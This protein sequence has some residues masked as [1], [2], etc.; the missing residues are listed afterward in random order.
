MKTN[1]DL[2]AHSA[3]GLGA[4]VAHAVV[5][6]AIPA[7]APTRS[8]SQRGNQRNVTLGKATGRRALL[9]NGVT[10]YNVTLGSVTHYMRAAMVL[11]MML[12][13]TA[14][15]WADGDVVEVSQASDFGANNSGEIWL[16]SKTYKLTSDIVL[17]DAYLHSSNTATIDLNGYGIRFNVYGT[18]QVVNVEG[19]LTIIDSNPSR[20]NYITLDEN[21]RGTS[22]STS[23]T[24]S[25]TCIKV[26]GGYITGGRNS[27]V[28][29]SGT[30]T[31][32]GGTIC[33]NISANSGGGVY[34]DA[35]GVFTMN[36]GT[37]ANNTCNGNDGVGGVYVKGAFIM[38]S[39]TVENNASVSSTYQNVR[40]TGGN[41]YLHGGCSAP[42]NSS[43]PDARIG[44]VSVGESDYGTITAS[45]ADNDKVTI[46]D[47]TYFKV[48][49]TVTLSAAPKMNYRLSTVS[50][51][52][53]GDSSSSVEVSGTGNTRTFT[54]PE[55]DVDVSAEY[56]HYV[57]E[58]SDGHDLN[59]AFLNGGDYILKNDIP[60]EKTSLELYQKINLD[61]NG[62]LIWPED[63][64]A[65]SVIEIYTGGD[66][67]L[68]DSSEGKEGKIHCYHIRRGVYIEGGKLTLEGGTITEGVANGKTEPIGK[69]GGGVCI[70]SGSFTMNGGKITGCNSQSR[71]EDGGGGG[72]YVYNGRFTMN[73]GEISNNS[74]ERGGGVFVR[75]IIFLYG[76]T[77]TS[78]KI[79]I[80]G[81]GGGVYY[82]YN[83]SSIFGVKGSPVVTGNLKEGTAD[84][85][86][87]AKATTGTHAYLTISGAL[88]ESAALWLANGSDY[89]CIAKRLDTSDTLTQREAAAFRSSDGTKVG[90]KISSSQ[91]KLGTPKTA[92][93][94]FSPAGGIFNTAQS[95]TISSTTDGATIYYTTDGTDPSSTNGTVYTAAIPVST[96]TTI[97]AIAIK[98]GLLNSEIATATYTI[99]N[100]TEA[101]V[102]IS[103][104]GVSNGAKTVTYGTSPFTLT[105]SADPAG[106]NGAWT[107]ASSDEQVATVDNTGKVTVKAASDEPVMITASYTSDASFGSAAISLTVNKATPTYTVPT[108]LTAT[109]GQILADVTLPD[110]WAWDDDSQLVGAVGTNSFSATFTPDD[111]DNYNNVTTNVS[112]TVAFDA[113]HFA[114]NGDGSYTIKTATGWGV[115]CDLLAA[116]G[117][118]TYFS[119]KTVKLSTDIGTADEPITRMAGSSQHDFTGTFDGQGHTLTV[120][121]NTSEKYAAPFRNVESGCVI[122]NLHVAGTITTSAM[123]AAGI[124]GNQFGS[125]TIRNCRVSVTISSSVGGDG[126]HGGF[127]GIKGNSNAAQLTIDGCV[128]DGKIVSTGDDATTQ[129]GGFVGWRKDKGSLTITNSLYAP[130]ADD[131]AVTDGAT[132][133]RNWSMPADA[134]CYYTATLGSAQGKQPHSV[135]AGAN[136]TIEPIALTGD[137]TAYDVSGIKAYSGGGIHYGDNLYYGSG[138]AVSLTLADDAADAPTG[139]ASQDG[140]TVSAGTLSGS[141][142]TMPDKDVVVTVRWAPDPEHFAKSADGSEYTIKTATGWNVFCD[143]LQDLNTYNRFS[144]KKVTLYGDIPTADEK[145]AGTS[146]VTRMAGTSQHDFCGTFDGQG[147]TLTVNLSSTY[148]QDYTAPFSYVTNAKANPGDTSDSPAA[149]RNLKVTGT[150]ESSHKFASGLVGGCWG[151]VD[152]ENS[153]VSTV[154][155][156]HVD[157]DG[158]HGG[159]VGRQGNGTLTIRGCVFDGQL[160]GSD[161]HSCAGFVGYNNGSTLNISNS[162]FAPASVTVDDDNCATFARHGENN[163]TNID[164]CYYT[165]TLGTE[166]GEEGILLFDS[167]VTATANEGVI[168]RCATKQYDVKLQGRTLYK[169]GK[170]NTLCLPFDVE[171]GDTE[172]GLT[173]SGTPLAGAEARP[174]SAAS[175]TGTTLTLTFGNPVST[176]VAGTPYIIK[177]GNTEGTEPT[178]ATEHIVNPV[179]S[180]VTISSTTAGSYDTQSAS[181]AVTTDA[182]VRFIGTYDQKTIDTEDKS[183]LFLGAGNTLYYPDGTGSGVTIGACRAYFKI[184]DGEALARQLTAFNI[185]FGEETGIGHTEITEITERAGAWYTLDGVRL[186]G[187]PT[188]RS[189]EGRLLPTGRKKG[190]YIHN[191]RKVVVP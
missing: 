74:A 148:G 16:E 5:A 127:V 146:A 111:T 182:R 157:G 135:T 119:G 79:P 179:F 32:N 9:G 167:G 100:K 27:G 105:A 95:V 161:T 138:D 65:E 22:V 20:I 172:D 58:I 155:D 121:Y 48:G 153:L 183:I 170:W 137:E 80:N 152:I 33:G 26:Y 84:D 140:Y 186:D 187:K 166:Q 10:Y 106:T 145:A 132:F 169:D 21:G 103:G 149:I 12:L 136:V 30:L 42:S 97:K 181:P 29:V 101:T 180:G 4:V 96:T 44:I 47:D 165:Q 17:N 81:E 77:I 55:Y 134:N 57:I 90:K 99:V 56:E 191:G 28:Y 117:G 107:W 85:I 158:T 92:Q 98:E 178:E 59:S 15:A 63:N 24:E 70:Y 128:F 93:P 141:T 112:V 154:I 31:M 120:D 110:N 82:S 86:Y 51:T 25:N 188:K 104:E 68:T 14:T 189:A 78:N 159:I 108:G 94:T 143:A 177:W 72:V 67:T 60:L 76:G 151:V 83:K 139:Y 164:N 54:M 133:A 142:L 61:L 13:T 184:G 18:N 147:H 73:G 89:D 123:N 2:S 7:D 102:S 46:G 173:F 185:D 37:I 75:R 144:G 174:L 190:L 1:N 176:L 66:L 160:L 34:V 163:V 131:N 41:F 49:R 36:G 125:V 62:K 126:T 87:L 150:V 39:G 109:F 171:D 91:I 115:F 116:D 50:V 8:L 168:S 40:T 113:D 162:L 35:N 11:L 23:G 124:V 6:H 114:D 45:A 53:S 175:I 69:S 88:T 156:S 130:Q 38:L 118:K 64:L 129:C 71:N 43:D 19:N 122:E 3:K 52:K